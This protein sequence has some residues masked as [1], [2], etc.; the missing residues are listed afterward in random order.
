MDGKDSLD[1]SPLSVKITLSTLKALPGKV[2]DV[3]N[4]EGEHGDEPLRIP[5]FADGPLSID[6]GLRLLEGEASGESRC[7]PS[8][9]FATVHS[10]EDTPLRVVWGKPWSTFRA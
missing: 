2:G 5:F 6:D 7:V 8:L 9:F 1:G 10:K 4:V 3:D